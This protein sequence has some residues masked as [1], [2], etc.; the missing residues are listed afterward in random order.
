MEFS[1]EQLKSKWETFVELVSSLHTQNNREI[2]MQVATFANQTSKELLAAGYINHLQDG[3]R[4]WTKLINILAGYLDTQKDIIKGLFFNHR[5]RVFM[6]RFIFSFR[7]S[8]LFLRV[9]QF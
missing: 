1:E 9:I 8:G 3:G 5:V 7:A 6:H 4:L 2:R